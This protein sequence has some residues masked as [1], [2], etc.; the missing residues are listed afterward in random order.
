MKRASGSPLP[1]AAC[2]LALAVASSGCS[3]RLLRPAPPRREW[4]EQ[5]TASTSEEPCT[6]SPVPVAADLIFG[7][8]LGTL[9]YIERNSGSPKIAFG[10][11]VAAVPMLISGVYGAVTVSRCRSYKS[12]FIDPAT[13]QRY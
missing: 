6:V 10:I 9:S 12:R 2:L 8:I 7:S 3:F 4:P 13:G 1:A 5:V 11:G